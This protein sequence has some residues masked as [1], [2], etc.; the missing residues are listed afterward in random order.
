MNYSFENDQLT[1]YF[2][3]KITS[4]N[5]DSMTKEADSI[6][7]SNPCSRIT[8]NMKDVDYI[9]SSGLRMILHILKGCKSFS[10][11][12]VNPE[13]YS[14]LEVSGFTEML[15]VKKT[16]R[17]ISTAGAHLLGRGFFSEVY[18]LDEETIVKKFVRDTAL[19]DIERECANAKR[20]FIRGVPCAITYD[21]VMADDKYGLVFEALNAGTMLEELKERP[22]DMDRLI[23]RYTEILRQ[24]HATDAVKEDFPQADALWMEKLQFVREQL[25]LPEYSKMEALLNAL[26]CTHN[27]VHSDCHMGN[28]MRNGND[29]LLID[30]DTLAVGN[31]IFE[32]APMYCSY[33]V[34]NEYYPDNSQQF[35]GISQETANEVFDKTF[36]LYFAGL[37]ESELEENMNK[38]KLLAYFHMLFWIKKNNPGDT[39]FYSHCYQGF[40]DYLEKAADLG[41]KYGA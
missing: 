40:R 36:R 41:L 3:G 8:G 28:I 2:S 14:I 34:F 5:A 19:Q 10:L 30:L 16:I 24:I 9:S 15:P 12:D 35:F 6:I 1:L 38:I 4:Q 21:V 33:Y 7:G 18:R 32:F 23:D 17:Q 27:F 25:T 31:P 26:P 39:G 13:V 37:S 29:Y 20:A 11:T 22:Q